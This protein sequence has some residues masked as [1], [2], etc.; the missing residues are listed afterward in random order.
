MTRRANNTHPRSAASPPF[1][2]AASAASRYPRPAVSARIIPVAPEMSGQTQGAR[3][4][5]ADGPA[6]RGADV[7][8]L[9]VESHEGRG[10]LV[11]VQPARGR[12]GHALVHVQV[13]PP[14]RLLVTA[15]LQ[16]RG[17]I[18][19][20]RLEHD[21][22]RRSVRLTAAADHAL[23]D[24][25]CR[26]SR[27]AA[28]TSSAAASVAPPANT[29]KAANASCW[30]S[31]SS[32]WLHSIV[33]SSVWWRS[34]MSRAVRRASGEARHPARWPAPRLPAA[35]H[36]R[37][38]SSSASGSP[39]R[40]AQSRATAGPVEGP[41]RTGHRAGARPSGRAW[42]PRRPPARRPSPALA[43]PAARAAR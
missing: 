25:A 19:P 33:A 39:S 2:A 32:A 11:C 26:T 17:R 3:G 28:V 7:V 42:S 30:T 24:Q 22:P 12:D 4:V 16:P 18:L 1:P 15:L 8:H 37:A 6:Q 9:P 34:A 20:H 38:A 14:N 43:P 40:R 36:A 21:Q 23:G 35:P 41:A 13:A 10:L 31:S 27:G 5:V 29:A